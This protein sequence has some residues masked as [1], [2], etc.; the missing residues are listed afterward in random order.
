MSPSDVRVAAM[1]ASDAASSRVLAAKR[2]VD[3]DPGNVAAWAA[4]GDAVAASGDLETAY[5]V[6]AKGLKRCTAVAATQAGEL[7]LDGGAAA[8]L[9][10][11]RAGRV[12]VG[13]TVQYAIALILT[14]LSY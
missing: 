10:L 11:R 3:A 7:A 13:R 8:G 6:Y 9:G 2:A 14:S 1:P 4:M 5:C 12:Q